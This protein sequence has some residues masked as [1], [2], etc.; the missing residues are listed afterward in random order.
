[1]LPSYHP[2]SRHGGIRCE[3]AA[4]YLA[5]AAEE[6]QGRYE[7]SIVGHSGET[8]GEDFVSFASP[9]RDRGDRL[10]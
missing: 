6:L 3:G 5:L 2:L 7:Y 1:M 9:P 8:D 4:R 10:K